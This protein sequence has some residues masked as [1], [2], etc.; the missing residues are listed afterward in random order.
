VLDIEHRAG[1]AC[2]SLPVYQRAVPLRPGRRVR[3]SRKVG[4]NFLVRRDD[5]GERTHFG[6][7]V[8]QRHA[9]FERE[10]R[11]AAARK[12]DDVALGSRWPELGDDVK[13]KILGEGTRCQFAIYRD[14]HG[15]RAFQSQRHCR[16]RVFRLGGTNAPRQTAEGALRAGVAVRADEREARLGDRLFGRNDMDDTLPLVTD[17]EKRQARTLGGVTRRADEFAAGWHDRA[18]P[19]TGQRIDDMVHR[20]ENMARIA[21]R[22]ASSFQLRQRY[23][24]SA[25]VQPDTVDGDQ[26]RSGSRRLSFHD[27]MPFPDLLEEAACR[28]CGSVTHA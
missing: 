5:G 1:I 17:I 24:A 13:R 26:H 10:G 18:V 6:G 23:A 14:A 16:Q 20:Y 27:L 8:A 22:A 9:R 19:P 15:A 4:E 12:F 25:L 28:R 21:N 7:H 3:T 11:H 2:Q